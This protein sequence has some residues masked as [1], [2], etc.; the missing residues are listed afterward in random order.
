LWALNPL[1]F[2]CLLALLNPYMLVLPGIGLA[3]LTGIYVWRGMAIGRRER[4]RSLWRLG[5]LLGLL[6]FLP[7][8]A[9]A[10]GR[11]SARRLNASLSAGPASWPLRSSE[12]G[13]FLTEHVEEVGRIALLEGLR[14]RLQ[15]NRLRPKP[16][17]EWDEADIICSSALFW[18][19]RMVS[20]EAW[21]TLYLRLA[22]RPR[23]S[24]LAMPALGIALALLLSPCAAAAAI[25]GLLA[26]LLLEGWIF[27]R[28][29]RQASTEARHRRKI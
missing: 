21:G 20:Y 13:I 17:S 28:K 24:W 26:V 5:P 27:A 18:R 16:S 23:L 1:L 19:V 8:L 25:A 15:T 11:L 12:G 10:W 9:R 14:H 2:L 7:F 29:V 6:Y 3:T 22:Y 4:L